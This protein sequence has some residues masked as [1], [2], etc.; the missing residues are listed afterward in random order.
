[1]FTAAILFDDCGSFFVLKIEPK[2]AFCYAKSMLKI[3][4]ADDIFLV[5]CQGMIISSL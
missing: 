4:L 3:R 2:L 1:M 5:L